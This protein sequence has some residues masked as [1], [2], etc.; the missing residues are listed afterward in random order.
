MPYLL[1]S[2]NILSTELSRVKS[3]K[4]CTFATSGFFFPSS[5]TLL[6]EVIQAVRRA[7]V[8]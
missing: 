1:T 8:L 2:L 7:K 6:K 5:E 4:M 3:A